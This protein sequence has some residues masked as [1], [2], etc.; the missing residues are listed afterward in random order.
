MSVDRIVR[1][2]GITEVLHFTTNKGC[3]GVLATRAL[4]AR[5]RL[6]DEEALEFILQVNAADRSRDAA[7]HDYV[8]LSISRINA[9]FFGTSGYWHR[10]KDIWWCI[11]SFS[12]EILGHAGVYFTTTNNMYSGVKRAERAEGLTA[13]FGPKVLHYHSSYQ[14]RTVVRDASLPEH[15]TTCEQA[16][17]LYP[18]EVSTDFLRAIY[19]ADEAH[20]DEVAGQMGVVDHRRIDIIVA[21]DK[22]KEFR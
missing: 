4:K 6:S 14:S 2:R 12:P 18:G 5:R 3:L 16:E 17:A 7:W 15:L 8:N 1:E 19:V 9:N 20:V 10:D 22:F 13:L 11:L 21:P